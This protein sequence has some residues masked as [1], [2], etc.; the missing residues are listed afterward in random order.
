MKQILTIAMLTALLAACKK[1]QYYL[2][3]DTARLQFGPAADRIYTTSFE[4]ADTVK[5]YTFYYEPAAVMEDTVYFDIYA[6]GGVSGKDRPFTLE[7]VILEGAENAVPGVHYKP[8]SDP[9]LKDL[10]VIKA[11]KVHDSVPVILL[12]DPS[13]KNKSVQL[14][15]QV[16]ANEHFQPGEARKLWRRVDFTD[17][18]SQPAAWNASAVQ[19][20]WGKYSRVKHSFMIEQT[21]EKWDQEFLTEVNTDYA[22]LTFWRL[23]L[24]TLLTDYNNAH[25]GEPLT[26]ETGETVVFP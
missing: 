4:M 19:Y 11:G 22:L 24:R 25:P 18:L 8:F 6:I 13:L 2:Y 17:M 7:Q 15:I 16:K 21:G 14:Q 23:K 1:D 5:P 3:N 10:Y 12:R 26:D 9:A 20:Y